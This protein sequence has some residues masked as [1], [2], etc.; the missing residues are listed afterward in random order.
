M[1]EEKLGYTEKTS[2]HG[3]D[4]YVGDTEANHGEATLHRTMK[5]R[6]IAMIRHVLEVD[7]WHTDG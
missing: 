3:V 7:P 2:D 4:S 1:A 6:H 5:N